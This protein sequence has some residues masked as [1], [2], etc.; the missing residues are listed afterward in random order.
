MKRLLVLLFL[1]MNFNLY[2]SVISDTSL[3]L[4]Y[5]S[6]TLSFS[7]DIPFKLN[8]GLGL[9]CHFSDDFKFNDPELGLFIN[10]RPFSL[11][12]F[13][14][15]AGLKFNY[16]YLNEPTFNNYLLGINFYGGGEFPIFNNFG[17]GLN[18]GYRF[19]E[20]SYLHKTDN[21]YFRVKYKETHQL[22]PLYL[23]L[24]FKYLFK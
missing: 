5:D 24:Y 19:G 15:V 11:K 6:L 10:Y 8:L 1:V 7:K 4:S 16:I 3:N 23:D 22:F 21:R 14:P 9:G 17:I 2:S 13:I 20:T 18:L 12:Y